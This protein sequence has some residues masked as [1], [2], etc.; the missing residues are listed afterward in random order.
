[1]VELTSIIRNAETTARR[2]CEGSH[3]Y[4]SSSFRMST[5]Q[6]KHTWGKDM[7]IVMIHGQN[8]KGSTWHIGHMLAD[9]IKGE[10]EI[11]EFFLPR[12]LNHFCL[13][14]YG[15]MKDMAI[16][17]YYGEKKKIADAMEN[18]DLLIFTSPNYCMMPSAPMKAFIDL[19][20]QYWLPHRPQ[21]CMFRKKAV[22]ISTTAGMGAGRVCTQLKRTLAYW[23]VPYIGKYAVSVQ[24]SGWKDV[25]PKKKEKIEKEITRL[26]GR[27]ENAKVG[28][29]SLY[30]RFMFRMMALTKKNPNDPEAEHWKK[31][32]WLDGKKPWKDE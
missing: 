13:G 31:Q 19:F 25:K 9:N 22:V 28:K 16:C 29:P 32:G 10:K 24:A 26:V 20:Y 11:T 18:A 12:D 27:V 5:K 3:G 2:N 15:C 21:A 7:R 1:M 8:H 23:G 30:I 17:P 4:Y 6:S 14:C